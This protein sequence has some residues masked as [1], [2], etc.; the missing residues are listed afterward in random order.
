MSEKARFSTKDSAVNT[1][2]S[3]LRKQKA[4]FSQTTSS[5]VTDILCLQGTIGN[6]VVQRLVESGT[7]QTKL[8]IGQ[9]GDVY[10]READRIAEQVMRM[11]EPRMQRQNEEEEEKK[12]AEMIQPERIAGQMTPSIQ[13]QVDEEDEEE[14]SIQPKHVSEQAISLIQRQVEEEEEEE[15][16]PLQTKLVSTEPALLQKQEE[17][18]ED[19]EE[20]LFQTKAFSVQ[21]LEVRPDLSSRIKSLKE[22]GQPLPKSVRVFF[23]RR[24]GYDFSRV[25]MRTDIQAADTTKAVK[26]K[27]FTIGSNVAFGVGQYSPKTLR[28]RRLLAH[29]LTHVVQ[30]GGAMQRSQTNRITTSGN[31][32]MWIQRGVL[33]WLKKQA[34]KVWGGIKGISKSTWNALKKAGSYAVKVAQR[35]GKGAAVLIEKYGKKVVGF[36]D[37]WGRKAIDWLKRFGPSVIIWIRRWGVRVIKWV[38]RWGVRVIKWVARWGVRVIKWVA[39]WGVR[40]IKWVARWGVRVINWLARWGVRVI[41]VIKQVAG[42]VWGCIKGLLDIPGETKECIKTL[43]GVIQLKP[44]FH[45]HGDVYEQEADKVGDSVFQAKCETPKFG[46]KKKRLMRI[47]PH[48]AKCLVKKCEPTEKVS[49]VKQASTKKM[50]VATKM[51]ITPNRVTG[52]SIDKETRGFMESR[53]GYDFSKV[54]IHTDSSADRWAGRFRAKAFT[55]GRDVYF[56]AGKYNPGSCT[57]RRLLG[58]ELTHVVQ[59]SGGATSRASIIHRNESL[60]KEIDIS[61]VTVVNK[62]NSIKQKLSAPSIQRYGFDVH[63]QVTNDIAKKD[64]KFSSDAADEIAEADQSVDKGWRHPHKI[65]PKEIVDLRVP[66]E[67]M[68]HFPSRTVAEGD[69]QKAI[70]RGNHIELGEAL[71]R[72]QD[73]FSHNFSTWTVPV[74]RICASCCWVLSLFSPKLASLVAMILLPRHKYGRFAALK[75]ICLRDYPDEDHPEQG[76]RDDDM[77]KGTRIWL[78][79]FLAKWPKYKNYKKPTTKKRP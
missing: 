58:H 49:H 46:G 1:G 53:L 50:S 25:R 33:G 40:V 67:D 69:V 52:Q 73:S 77:K 78:K 41:N 24:F 47:S 74:R 65:T 63:Y 44:K 8:K 6:Q 27:A 56:A 34:K 20:E 43:G 64:A 31:T 14:E 35:L 7:I 17:E 9:P 32:Q 39:R 79:T 66:G 5:P 10:E 23:E 42:A 37:K 62:G 30:Q 70:D 22:G 55:I 19:R 28:G 60:G 18:Q 36:L 4:D 59:Q 61:A 15:E 75:H 68:I 38:A 26:A 72:F 54:R 13:R 48:Y 16:Q 12:E 76:A 11:P 57:G 21:R 2:K 3:I 71:H 45:N 51:L 29:E